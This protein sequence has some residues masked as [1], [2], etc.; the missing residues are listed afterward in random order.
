MIDMPVYIRQASRSGRLKVMAVSRTIAGHVQGHDL[1]VTSGG[2][3]NSSLG[4]M[5]W[6]IG[7]ERTRGGL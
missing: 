1:L 2:R 7:L 6:L 3:G 5:D 4:R